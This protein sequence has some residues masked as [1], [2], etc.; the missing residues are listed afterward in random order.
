LIFLAVILAVGVALAVYAV[1]VYNGLAGLRE[2]IKVAWANIDVLLKQRHDELAKLLETCKPHMQ[3]EGDTLEKLMRARTAISEASASGNV[4]A[5]GAAEQRL[6]S[7]MG[8]LFAFAQSHPQL[9]GDAA[10]RQLQTRI[11]SLEEAIGDLRELY[12]E[13][14]NLNN[15][16]VHVLPDA[17][18]ARW[19]GFRAAHLLEF[20]PDAKR[21]GG[22]S[23]SFKA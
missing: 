19:F 17:V 15:I 1:G 2:T 11:S 3:F 16:R 23:A 20:S 18:L 22:V 12:N 13:Q 9:Q 14:V 5:V 21:S 10:F 7:G 8:R 4:A 6:R